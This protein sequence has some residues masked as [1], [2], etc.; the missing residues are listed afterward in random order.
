MIWKSTHHGAKFSAASAA[1]HFVRS[2]VAEVQP[3]ILPWF[4]A[5]AK[6][7][8]DN[9]TPNPARWAQGHA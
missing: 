8:E 9:L 3:T 1:R 7:A 5:G 2:G 6:M 4:V